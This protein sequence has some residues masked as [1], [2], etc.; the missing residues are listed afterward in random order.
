[1]FSCPVQILDYIHDLYLRDFHIV[2][3][4]AATLQIGEI[5]MCPRSS[6]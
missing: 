3:P 4:L 5:F 6:Y 2:R 1:M